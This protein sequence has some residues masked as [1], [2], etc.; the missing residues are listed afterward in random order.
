MGIIPN[1]YVS[2]LSTQLL[3]WVSR[4]GVFYLVW[5]SDISISK[6][7]IPKIGKIFLGTSEYILTVLN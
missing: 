2:Y 1:K 4:K 7:A 5:K 6:M 3:F